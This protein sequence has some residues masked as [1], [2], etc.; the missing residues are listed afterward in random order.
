MPNLFYD[1]GS[2]PEGTTGKLVGFF[3]NVLHSTKYKRIIKNNIGIKESTLKNAQILDIGCGGGGVLKIFAKLFPYAKIFGVD[4]SYDMVLLSKFVNRK[5]KSVNITVS[6][7]KA[8]SLPFA[9]YELDIVTAFET[10]I[11]WDDFG[12]ALLEIRRVMKD[13]GE[14][15]IVNS[16]PKPGSKEY[17]NY[18]FANVQEYEHSLKR[19]GFSKVDIK[20]FNR[21]IIILCS[22]R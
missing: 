6:K 7:A 22:K 9:N 20:V 1:M 3:M 19:F 21:T 18:K 15:L 13:S 12:K 4:Q 5:L 11:Y 14:F 10:I 2:K 17:N 8:D 16:I